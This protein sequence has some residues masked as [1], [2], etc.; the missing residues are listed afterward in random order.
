[1]FPNK[2]DMVRI[3]SLGARW[4]LRV[5]SGEDALPEL[6][7]LSVSCGDSGYRRAFSATKSDLVANAHNPFIVFDRAAMALWPEVVTGAASSV[8][9]AAAVAALKAAV[10]E[11]D[12]HSAG[13][14]LQRIRIAQE[15]MGPEGGTR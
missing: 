11:E 7:R 3:A 14:A 9:K 13:K 12:W 1:M 4:H 5:D 15:A 6:M 10:E 8:S 2:D